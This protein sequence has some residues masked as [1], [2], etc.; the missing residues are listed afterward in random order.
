MVICLCKI[1][2]YA[3]LL[4]N[5][6]VEGGQNSINASIEASTETYH[7]VYPFIQE[8][9][10]LSCSFGASLLNKQ[11]ERD[12]PSEGLLIEKEGYMLEYIPSVRGKPSSRFSAEIPDFN[13]GFDGIFFANIR[14]GLNYL[15]IIY[16]HIVYTFNS[17][18]KKKQIML[19]ND[20]FEQL[21]STT[22]LFKAIIS[23]L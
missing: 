11:K 3:I 8:L 5:V 19:S 16:N 10:K 2:Y 13:I 7:S 22:E 23:D 9:Q 20:A 15:N 17:Q 12:Y 6:T 1:I 18:N 14:D 4:I 21:K